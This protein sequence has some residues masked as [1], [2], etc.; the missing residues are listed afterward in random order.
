[1]YNPITI[2]KKRFEEIWKLAAPYLK[3]GKRK[4]FVLHTKGVIKA[5]GLLL[6]QKKGNEDV[7]IP[8]AILHDTGWSKIPLNLQKTKD[9]SKTKRAM[10]LHLIYS[11]PIINE[12]L[13]KLRYDKKQI[14]EITDIVLAHKFKNPKD[15]NKR[16]LIDADTL[17]D[18]FK[19]QFYGD[20]KKYNQTPETLYKIRKN[21]KFYT[22]TARIIFNKGLEKR[23]KE[24]SGAQN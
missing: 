19:E 7:L 10:G 18:A 2:M 13:T 23:R 9:K 11:V 15:L 5:V 3:K 21:N 12:I 1:M 14:K 17:A 4:N 6:K 16:L 24:F 20:C 8:A 22:K